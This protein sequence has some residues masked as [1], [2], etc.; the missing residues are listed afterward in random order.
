MTWGG[1]TAGIDTAF[2][3]GET[4]SFLIA[5]NVKI[6]K[7]D[8]VRLLTSGYAS[9]QGASAAA[10]H[11]TGDQF[12]GVA[13]ES[14]DNTLTGHVIGGKKITVCT[15]HGSVHTFKH[16]ATTT[17]TQAEVGTF[18]FNDVGSAAD[19]QTV[20]ATGTHSCQVGA[21]VEIV[22]TTRVRVAITPFSAIAS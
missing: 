12:V 3:E 1:A 13:M 4:Q 10:D 8:I 6:F 7:G 17:F 2:A 22:S 14:V 20:S 11:A 19:S 16:G 9:A 21:I 5:D 15:K 18:A